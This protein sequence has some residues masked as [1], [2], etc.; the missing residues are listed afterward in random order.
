MLHRQY[1]RAE[2]AGWVVIVPALRFKLMK[3]MALEEPFIMLIVPG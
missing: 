2:T 1:S 3:L